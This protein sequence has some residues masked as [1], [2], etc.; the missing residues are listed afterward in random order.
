M[1]VH[2][3]LTIFQTKKKT[4]THFSFLVQVNCTIC[5]GNFTFYFFVLHFSVTVF[6]LR[7]DFN[8]SIQYI[9]RYCDDPVNTRSFFPTFVCPFLCLCSFSS[10]IRLFYSIRYACCVSFIQH[11]I[12]LVVVVDIVVCVVLLSI[13]FK[14]GNNK[15]HIHTRKR[16]KR[17]KKHNNT[18]CGIDLSDF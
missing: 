10:L 8:K 1:L 15:T 9:C 12:S 13:K 17:K 7:I 6:Q 2:F 5:S 3:N 14:F 16:G 18:E 11:S 4:H